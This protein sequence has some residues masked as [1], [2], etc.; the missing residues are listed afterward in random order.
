MSENPKNSP[1]LVELE[2]GEGA[3][4]FNTKLLALRRGEDGAERTVIVLT[5]LRDLLLGTNSNDIDEQLRV[6]SEMWVAEVI[7]IPRYKFCL[8]NTEADWGCLDTSQ[9][10]AS[11]W[12]S[13]RS[14]DKQ[15]FGPKI[16]QEPIP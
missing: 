15:I 7:L 6:G 1:T 4:R 3:V 16:K 8:N 10:L 14:W 11:N 2:F 5:A 12:G 13:I 9:Q